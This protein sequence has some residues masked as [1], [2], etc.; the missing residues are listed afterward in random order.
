[1]K[2][3]GI[4]DLFI[5]YGK[6]RDGLAPLQALGVE[7]ETFDWEPGGFEEL[8][9]VNL[10]VETKGSGA[11]DPPP[12]VYAA[13]TD[14]DIIVTQFCTIPAK[15]IDACPKLKLIGVLRAGVE[16][17]DVGHATKR[18]ALVMNTPGRNADAVA[19]F[20]VGMIICEA[21]NITRGF[22][23]MKQGKWIRTYPNS[24]MI[25][26]MPGK[27]VGIIGLGEIGRK[28]AK[29]L[30]GFDMRLLAYDPFVKEPPEGIRMIDL[31]TLMAESDFVTIHARLT[32]ETKGLIGADLIRKMKPSAYL[33]N[34]SRSA[35]VDE[36][37]LGA[38]L[39]GKKIAG[40]ALDVFD[41]EP[42][43]ADY[44]LVV[45]D[46]VTVTPHMAGG[47]ND[48][49]YNS[50]KLLGAEIIKLL[51]GKEPRSVLNRELMPAAAEALRKEKP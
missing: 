10:K 47:S 26:D 25:P 44:P 15:L 19:D 30:A 39:R 51:E 8:Q 42:P 20:T 2:L 4:G 49:F 38:A 11:Y 50:P 40:A 14:A 29:R 6:I 43:G 33:V 37:A 17:V 7:I 3:V 46:N 41:V 45:L 48:A 21:R 31:P 18:G 12:Q 22:L 1:M 27:T 9:N 24:G 5:P 28:V 35:L 36:K 16:N 34:T 32:P 13:V 23:G